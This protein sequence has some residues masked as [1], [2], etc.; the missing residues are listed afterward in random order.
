M[1]DEISLRSHH[2]TIQTIYG[3]EC[4]I[5]HAYF[6]G[7]QDGLTKIMGTLNVPVDG[8]KEL[9]MGH[10]FSD[11]D[12]TLFD[13][14]DQSLWQ[15]R[16]RTVTF[17]LEV[18]L[19]STRAPHVNFDTRFVEH[20]DLYVKMQSS[21]AG[22][23]LFQAAA[24]SEFDM[25][26]NHWASAADGNVQDVIEEEGALVDKNTQLF[27]DSVL[28]GACTVGDS[29]ADE[30]WHAFTNERAKFLKGAGAARLTGGL[31]GDFVNPSD[32]VK[33][34]VSC[35]PCGSA[36][37]RNADGPVR[38]AGDRNGTRPRF[39][40]AG[41]SD[42]KDEDTL[43]WSAKPAITQDDATQAG[44]LTAANAAVHQPGN[45][46]NEGASATDNVAVSTITNGGNS[47]GTG[48]AGMNLGATW[49]AVLKEL[50]YSKFPY[51]NVEGI[52]QSTYQG[53]FRN[54]AALPTNETGMA[55]DIMV[56]G[57]SSSTVANKSISGWSKS[58]AVPDNIK[59]TLICTFVN[60][61]DKIRE[62]ISM[63]NFK[64]DQPATVLQYDTQEEYAG[65]IYGNPS[66]SYA[67]T[68]PGMTMKLPIR[69]NHLAYAISIVAFRQAEDWEIGNHRTFDTGRLKQSVS[70]SQLGLKTMYKGETGKDKDGNND[71]TDLAPKD[72]LNARGAESMIPSKNKCQWPCYKAVE[73]FKTV[74]PTKVS[75]K[76]S[77]RA[78]YE[79][80]AD[81]EVGVD[82]VSA[83]PG[84]R[85]LKGG[86]SLL[87]E[88]AL[89]NMSYRYNVSDERGSLAGP[90]AMADPL[91]SY[92]DMSISGSL[93][94]NA[95][96][97][98]INFSLNPSDELSNSGCLA[99]QTVNNPTLELTFS[100][101]CRVYVY[102]HHYCL[103]QID[104]N[105]GTI[106]RSLDV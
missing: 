20:L 106:T 36:T 104:S 56:E 44:L 81:S 83:L 90:D 6:S 32:H 60:Y 50:F 26:K 105:T 47:D 33:N 39:Y 55:S 3:K 88:S 85:L 94:D 74:R 101:A 34:V 10:L 19:A 12:G 91:A 43:Y 76:A 62:E 11:D 2:R 8:T 82:Q 37:T 95:A 58:L 78:I 17:F 30:R 57:G 100:E 42:T 89:D 27:K 5:K 18:P 35:A 86:G 75:L 98:V 67:A 63:E 84:S 61:H 69:S 92:G 48:S 7:V 49:K 21:S 24:V 25:H 72:H 1:I 13:S 66:S 52:N 16:K 71:A 64:D 31:T 51:L 14:Q 4:L 103:I 41:T 54:S 73:Q 97:T 87:G 93:A 65:V 15:T 96:A 79:V 46:Y 29:S 77:G 22:Q 99:L 23:P 102:V 9:D 80:S 70:L 68:Q 45:Y 38:I 59:P 40:R 28:S 53:K